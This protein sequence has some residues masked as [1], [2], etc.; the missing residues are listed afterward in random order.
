[1]KQ[2][3]AL[4]LF[5]F[6]WSLLRAE[7]SPVA[8]RNALEAVRTAV[9]QLQIHAGADQRVTVP[10]TTVFPQKDFNELYDADGDIGETG[11][12]S[13][14]RSRAF[15]SSSRSYLHGVG[16]YLTP[17]ERE[18]WE[19]DLQDWWNDNGSGETRNP[20]W[21]GVFNS[22]LRVD[23]ATDPSTP[24][25][26]LPPQ[27]YEEDPQ[28]LYGEFDR[29]QLPV[30]LVSGNEHFDFDPWVDSSYPPG[31]L[32]P[33][34]A[35]PSPEFS[36][37][38]VWVVGNGSATNATHSANGLDGRVKALKVATDGGHYAYWIG[39]ESLKAN[40]RVNDPSTLDPDSYPHDVAENSPEYRNR[41]LAPQRNAW[42]RMSDLKPYFAENPAFEAF[43]QNFQDVF[44]TDQ[45]QIYGD[46]QSQSG[47]VRSH[48]HD[49]TPHSVSLLTDTALGGLKKDLTRYLK[50]G[51]GRGNDDPIADPSRY[52][53]HDPRFSAWGGSNSGFPYSSSAA[54]DGIPTFGQ[55]RSWFQNEA[56]GP[57]AGSVQPDPESGTVPIL[58]YV[59]FQN[60]LSYDGNSKMIRMHWA[61][62]IMLWNPL[63]VGLQNASYDIEMGVLPVL[64]KFLLINENPTLA[65][66]QTLDPEA[67]WQEWVLP[68]SYSMGPGGKPLLRAESNA[69]DGEVWVHNVNTPGTYEIF[70][71]D[72][73]RPDSRDS[74]HNPPPDGDTTDRYMVKLTGDPD[75]FNSGFGPWV[76]DDDITNATSDA[77]GRI[78]YATQ[79]GQPTGMYFNRSWAGSYYKTSYGLLA[80]KRIF[81]YIAPHHATNTA[82]SEVMQVDRPFQF[83][84][85][86]SFEA[87]EV[88]VFT[89][90]AMTEWTADMPILLNHGYDPDLPGFFWSNLLEVIDGPP[91]AESETLKWFASP[92]YSSPSYSQLNPRV[93]MSLESEAFFKTTQFGEVTSSSAGSFMMGRDFNPFNPF[94]YYG[95]ENSDPD[96]PNGDKDGDGV[97]NSKETLPKFVQ[98]WRQLY[99]FN[100]FGDHLRTQTG[101]ETEASNWSSGEMFI[102]PLQM[103]SS[104]GDDHLSSVHEFLP[105]FSRLNFGAKDFLE[106]PITEQTRDRY[107]IN[108]IHPDS[109][110][111]RGKEDLVR[112]RYLQGRDA[113]GFGGPNE[114][115]WDGNQVNPDSRGFILTST[116]DDGTDINRGQTHVAIRSVKHQ[117]TEILSLGQLQHVN[118]SPYVWQPSFPIGHSDASGQT[119]REAIAGIHS[120]VMGRSYYGFRDN[121]IAGVRPNHAK[122]TPGNMP[123]PSGVLF[124]SNVHPSATEE[125]VLNFPIS[126][127]STDTLY[128]P[129]NTML[130]LSYLLN[131]N[132]WDQYY[133]SAITA[134]P[135]DLEDPLPH[136]RLQFNEKAETVD[137]AE[138]LDFDLSA[139]YQTASGSLNVNSTSV[140]AWKA[141]LSS[142]R[143][144]KLGSD[145]GQ[146]P[147]GTVPVVHSLTPLEDAITFD[148]INQDDVEIAAVNTQKDYR[149]VLSGFRY[150]D[151]AMIQTL[152]ERIVDE[153]RLRGPFYS[154]SDFVNRRLA[155]PSGSHQ[156]GSDWYTARTTADD[157][158]WMF[159]TYDPFPGL[160]GLNGALQRALNIS[161]INGGVNHPDLGE[162]GSGAGNAYDMV[163]SVRIKNTEGDYTS[164]G[165]GGIS[166][167]S[168]GSSSTGAGYKYSV[169]PAIR[170]HLDTEHITASPAGEAGQLFQ[171]AAG[172]VTQGDLLSMI[173]S[174]LTAR[175]DTFLV[176][177][178]GDEVDSSGNVISTARIEAVVQRTVNPV[179]PA[180]ISGEDQYR[181]TTL[182][183]RKFEI[184]GIRWLDDGEY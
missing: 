64:D 177:A 58:T 130:D 132:L 47:A 48:F 142:F 169:D 88:R 179:T 51:D 44:S 176:R 149:H 39:D 66:R 139:A 121:I 12:W 62:M 133:L 162:D 63:D 55:L 19:Q 43:G 40:F 155:P 93:K 111:I 3:V 146:N 108:N 174:A 112:Y 53:L 95:S 118:L 107:G 79:A 35:L 87:G 50:D 14:Y 2:S 126:T 83:R 52:D 99:D 128:V 7:D 101:S 11:M 21:V 26:S 72:F 37:S 74:V 20:H 150:L 103:T 89:L 78:Y 183:G 13:M 27:I 141:L 182:D 10:A 157:S 173:G 167:T 96:A 137:A 109:G 124:S 16:T 4:S 34:V 104:L 125:G 77:F 23:R 134:V 91:S 114:V 172:F 41:L 25:T 46:S 33:D 32:T 90:N 117:N 71:V 17:L 160:H 28:T 69:N 76:F 154:L 129:G 24:P 159:P 127:Y 1:M 98:F 163:Y 38:T 97:F 56:S 102:A 49:L 131:E 153:V 9:E 92:H 29:G 148:A 151:D 105:A 81:A 175:G 178:Y 86:T 115:R 30:W 22:S 5:I 110:Y 166:N 135:T 152:A 68:Y 75:A 82:A 15:T 42:E 165:I 145:D 140:E 6:S 45:L 161:G 147:D 168:T 184:I 60:G 85:N 54:L 80:N 122:P 119:D 123:F 67:D 170:S 18:N 113:I 59:H 158:I 94:T 61:P 8:K 57:G 180:G 143:D 181:P 84:I 136:S 31:Y 171:G 156:Q 100:H 73:K 65:E 106:H 120:R 70:K 36:D 164:T 138:L 144:L 116:S